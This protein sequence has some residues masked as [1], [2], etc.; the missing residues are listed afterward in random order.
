MLGQNNFILFGV[1][2]VNSAKVKNIEKLNDLPY[3]YAYFHSGRK[4]DGEVHP[5]LITGE[6]AN[7][8]YAALQR[9]PK[10]AAGI[11]AV[12]SGSFKSFNESVLLIIHFLLPLQP[13]SWMLKLAGWIE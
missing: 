1:L 9:S 7:I 6:A 12:G 8:A 10:G 11:M 2:E 5:V 13:S 4:E 3:V